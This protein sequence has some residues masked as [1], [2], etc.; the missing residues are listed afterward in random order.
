[1][2][3]NIQDPNKVYKYIDVSKD[4]ETVC[5]EDRSHRY[6]QCIGKQTQKAI[7]SMLKLRSISA[8]MYDSHSKYDAD[9]DFV[10]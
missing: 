5:P 8:N 1:M 10:V 2:C 6:D 9:Y 4:T 3:N 7:A